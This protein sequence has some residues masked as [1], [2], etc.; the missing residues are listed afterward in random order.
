MKLKPSNYFEGILQLRNVSS[1]VVNFALSEISGSGVSIAKTKKL[2]NGIDIYVSRQR[3]LRTLASRL[4]KRFGGQII[5]SRKLHTRKMLTSRDVYRVNLLF[6]IPEFKKN[7]IIKYKGDKIKIIS[8]GKK[9][10]AKNT[11]TG[12][13]LNLDYRDLMRYSMILE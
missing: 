2:E 4:Q 1:A 9:V 13:K 7:D 6:R 11:V 10:F 8:I 3:F 12:M 5:F